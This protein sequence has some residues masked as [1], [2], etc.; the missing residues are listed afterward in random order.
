M[1]KNNAFVASVLIPALVLLT[2][3]IVIPIIG[4]FVISL[5]DYNPLRSQNT[6]LG[7]DNYSRLAGDEVFLSAR[8][9]HACATGSRVS[10]GRHA[11]AMRLCLS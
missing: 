7:L 2:I 5:F 10:C 6:F 9:E 8:L 1:K 3:F 4:S 11:C